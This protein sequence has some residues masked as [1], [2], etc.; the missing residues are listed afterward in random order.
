M[1]V[2]PTTALRE[3]RQQSI[4]VVGVQ[5]VVVTSAPDLVTGSTRNPEHGTNDYEDQP[6][7]PQHG[8]TQKQTQYRKDDSQDDHAGAPPS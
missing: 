5:L 3:S 6:D 2:P 4:G 8:N 7:Y 1:P